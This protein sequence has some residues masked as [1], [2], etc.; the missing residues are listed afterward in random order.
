VYSLDEFTAE[1]ER[2]SLRARASAPVNYAAVVWDG[3]VPP[4]VQQIIDSDERVRARFQGDNQGLRDPSD[5]AVDMSLACQLAS[6]GV[7]P[8][9]VEQALMASRSARIGAKNKDAS[10]YRRTV[11]RAV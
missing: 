5:S 9:E 6:R 3:G 11:E 4:T 10:Y 2:G 8:Q 1:E 7:A